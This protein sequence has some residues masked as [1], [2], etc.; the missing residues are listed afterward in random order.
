[1]HCLRLASACV[2]QRLVCAL[3]EIADRALGNAILEVGIDSAEGEL[4]PCIVAGLSEGIVLE[5][6]VIPVVVEDLHAVLGGECLEGAFGSKS[7][8]GCII[9]LEV[10]KAQTAEVVNEDGGAPV[11]PVGEFAFHL[12]DKSDF[13]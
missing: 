10:D 1:M 12:C 9:D 3:Q 13:S 11:A 2:E 4:L 8:R 5:T 6:P 7:F